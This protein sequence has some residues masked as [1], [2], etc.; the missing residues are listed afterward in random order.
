MVLGVLALAAAIVAGVTWHRG[1]DERQSVQHHQHTLETLRHV[2]DRR[3]QSPWPVPRRRNGASNGAPTPRT[4]S[5]AGRPTGS[6]HAGAPRSSDNGAA[7]AKREA[8]PRRGAVLAR[9]PRESTTAPS[10]APASAKAPVREPVKKEPVKKPSAKSAGAR[11]ETVVFEDGALDAEEW[12]EPLPAPRR[13]VGRLPGAVEQSRRDGHARVRRTRIVAGTAVVVVVGVAVGSVLAFGPSP[14]HPTSHTA[15]RPSRPVIGAG[16]GVPTTAAP[17][18]L[19]TPSA[20]T[21]YSATYVAPS[22]SYTVAID[23]SAVCWVMATQ[24]STGKVVWTGTIAAGASHSMSVSG[25]LV[26]RLGAPSDAAVTMD[27]RPVQLPTGFRAPFDLTFQA[28]A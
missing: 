28:T 7:R 24:A 27:G 16:H 14:S 26:V 18:N 21:A 17:S 11:R 12:A 13:P 20:P 6:E 3:Q 10:S 15:T 1:A 4:A 2:A 5:A 8:S 25:S 22:S 23:V 9:W 19:L